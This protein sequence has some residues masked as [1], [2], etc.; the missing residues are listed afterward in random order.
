MKNKDKQFITGLE[1]NLD[2]IK[3][4]QAAGAKVEGDLAGA[5]QSVTAAQGTPNTAQEVPAMNTVASGQGAPTMNAAPTGD[6]LTPAE[7][8]AQ[9]AQLAEKRGVNVPLIVLIAI[10]ILAL[11]AVAG[12]AATKLLGNDEQKEPGTSIEGGGATDGGEGDG[13]AGDDDSTDI[14]ELAV[15]DEVVQRLWH[16]FD[17]IT[18]PWSQTK[19]FYIMEGVAQGNV[20]NMLMTAVA[21]SQLEQKPECAGDY[22][23]GEDLEYSLSQYG[24][25]DVEALQAKVK[26]IFG[27]EIELATGGEI[28]NY[29]NCHGWT[30]SEENN[31]IYDSIGPG[32]G[33]ACTPVI[34]REIEKAE[35]SGDNI[36]IYEL[37]YMESCEGIY[38]LG[39]E[40]NTYEKEGEAVLALDSLKLG[41]AIAQVTEYDEYGFPTGTVNPEGYRN[42]FDEFKWTFTKN[43]EGNYVFAGLERL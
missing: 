22:T 6:F 24:C 37:A 15:D 10:V 11:A 43:A 29:I 28:L 42:Q 39:T 26:E 30:L 33:G 34:K 5:G 1:N 27:K 16:N 13:D 9:K 14:E 7:E 12:M 36:Y 32:C 3:A 38:H 20:D 19:H 35:R 17:I 18:D 8:Q 40:K 25:Y 4:E 21:L 41:E 2:E 23:L 31:E